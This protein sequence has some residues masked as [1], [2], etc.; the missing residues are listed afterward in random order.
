V[1][2][3]RLTCHVPAIRQKANLYYFY[4]FARSLLWL[5]AE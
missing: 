5:F 2:P 4:A 3:Q 1:F